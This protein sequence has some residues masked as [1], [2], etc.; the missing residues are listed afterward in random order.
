[1]RCSCAQPWMRTTRGCGCFADVA[2]LLAHDGI[3]LS[4]VVVFAAAAPPS[5]PLLRLAM[6]SRACSPSLHSRTSTMRVVVASVGKLC[7]ALVLDLAS[8]R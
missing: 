6:I 8:S 5:L 1:M 2:L 4:G 7:A 3:P